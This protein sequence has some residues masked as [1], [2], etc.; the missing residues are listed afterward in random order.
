MNPNLKPKI[1]LY[2][3]TRYNRHENYDGPERMLYGTD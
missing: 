2:L 3:T 1:I